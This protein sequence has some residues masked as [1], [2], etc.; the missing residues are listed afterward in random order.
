MM[1]E[2]Q[3]R[4][5]DEAQDEPPAT[6]AAAGEGLIWQRIRET[7]VAEITDGRYGPGDRL[8]T[9]AAL[10]R[11]FGVNRHTVRRAL[12]TLTEAGLIHVRRG[13]GAFVA[14]HQLDYALGA[15]TR[16]SQNL[17]THGF[18]PGREILRLETAGA[19]AEEARHLKVGAGELV[20]IAEM[21]GAGDG[22]PL[23]YSRLVFPGS[24]LPGF[25]QALK[26]S[27]S[28][29]AALCACGVADYTRKWTRLIAELP[30]PMIA[31]HLKMAPSRPCIRTESLNV[32]A[33]GTPVE[34][35]YSWFCSDRVQLVVEPNP[36]RPDPEDTHR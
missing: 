29:T 27:G 1:N 30:G 25:P 20:H 16:F 24:R 4:D 13:S 18:A 23:I 2:R 32:D 10:S 36:A 15:R 7:L 6:T 3:S 28:V 14:E 11:R 17:L 21:L 9:E 22:A 31:R 19:R 12:A 8:P 33:A 34:Y 35:G 26:V 5:T